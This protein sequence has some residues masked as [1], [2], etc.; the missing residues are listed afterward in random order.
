MKIVIDAGHGLYTPGKRAPDDSMR[1]WSFNSATATELEKMLKTHKSVEV[2][3]VDDVTGATDVPLRERC[4]K[5]NEFK[6]KLYISIHANA[7]GFKWSSAHG[8]ETFVR[9]DVYALRGEAFLIAEAVQKNLVALTGR[10]D[11]GVKG[12]GYGFHVLRGTKMP[13]I[14]VECGFMTNTEELKLL[15]SSQYR[16]QVAKAIY[17]AVSKIYKL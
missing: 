7:S 17:D 3:R 14:L 11:R 15:K 2:L 8:I 1:E 10:R 16:S 4:K 5:A 6:G 12:D 9:N 13:A